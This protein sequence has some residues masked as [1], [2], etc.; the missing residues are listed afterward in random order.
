MKNERQILAQGSRDGACF[1]Y[2]LAN[3]VQAL[4]KT[5]FN[6]KTWLTAVRSLP[7]DL[8]DFLSGR[9]TEKIDD[10]PDLLISL[11]KIFLR[12]SGSATDLKWVHGI[13]D[14][15]TIKTQLSKKTVLVVEID[16]G[17]HWVTVVDTADGLVLSAC[18]AMALCST[19]KYSE[20]TS[21]VYGRRF[22]RED[23]T[24]ELKINRERVLKISL[25]T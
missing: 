6:E 7:F 23:S 11:A 19:T 16:S 12:A 2:G 25:V 21:D 17:G 18:S 1:L 22:N 14:V 3:A 9:G 5:S 20:L 10:E 4:T 24:A 13:Y 15:L 8:S